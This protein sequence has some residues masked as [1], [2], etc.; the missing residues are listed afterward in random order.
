MSLNIF[1]KTETTQLLKNALICWVV[2]I[3]RSFFRKPF[4]LLPELGFVH[5]RR[6]CLISFITHFI[7]IFLCRAGL[8]QQAPNASSGKT[9]PKTEI[10]IPGP[11][12]QAG[13]FKKIFVGEHYRD[14]WT[15]PLEVPVLDLGAYAGGLT[16]VKEGGGLQTTTLRLQAV[17]G[18]QYTFRSLDKDPSRVLPP[19]LRD[20]FASN[21]LQDQTS[22]AHPYAAL[23]VAP[24]AEAVGV[25][26]ATPELVIMPDE[27][28]LGEFRQ[29]FAGMLGFIEERPDE[30]PEGQPGFAESE[31]VVGTDKLFE[32]LEAD[33]NNYVDPKT[34]LKARLLDIFVGDWDRSADQWRWALF[35]QSRQ[36]V[37]CPIPRDRDHAFSKFDGLLPSIF[38]LRFVAP[39][40]EG[41]NK[42]KPDLISL[43]YSGRHLDRRF[44]PRLSRE[45]FQKIASIF[46]DMLTDSV[47][48]NAV[49]HLPEPI[50]ATSGEALVKKLKFRRYLLEEG[51]Y[52]YYLQLAKYVDLKTC[53]HPDYVEVIRSDDEHVQV[54]IDHLDEKNGAKNDT[55][56]FQR[57]FNRNETHEIRLY[58]LGGNDKVVISGKVDKSILVRLIGGSGKDEI[59]DNSK[60]N[61][62]FLDFIPLFPDAANKTLIYDTA[63]DTKIIAGP[64]SVLKT[65]KFDSVVNF[66]EEQPAVRDYGYLTVPLPYLSVDADNGLF[67]GIGLSRYYYGF[68]KQ[69]YAFKHAF[70]GNYAFK[71]S[72]YQLHYLGE[73][74]LVTNRFRFSLEGDAWVPREVRNFYGFGNGT[75]RDAKR[76][77]ADFYRVR[78]VEYM[79]RPAFHYNAA[80]NFQFS[81]GGA[82][83]HF[84]TEFDADTTFTRIT[85]PYGVD[86]PT[87]LEINT[88]LKLDR[89]DHPVSAQ[90]GFYLSAKLSHFPQVFDNE[91]AFT[92]SYLDGRIYLTPI[93]DV[94]FAFQSLAQKVWGSFPYYEAA[95]LGG[96]ESLRGFRRFRFAGDAALNGRAEMRMKFFRA[97]VIVPTSF[98]ILLFGDT[99][100]VWFKNE[101]PGN[102]HTAFGAGVWFAPFRRRVTFSIS[103]ANSPEGLHLNAGGGFAF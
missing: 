101:S 47:I 67:L 1:Q 41:F 98:G 77:R 3:F 43:T 20:T 82:V 8:A 4:W 29:R 88:G 10:R 26:H 9:N 79:A 6:Y 78:S 37:W 50:Y 73:Y 34:F 74:I 17:N 58:L 89:R 85:R 81:L 95:F 57:T 25:L 92:K 96:R 32:R 22:T 38:D 48:E 70:R 12:Y 84:D 19:D 75:T 23:V 28:R 24:L 31:K 94:T 40:F 99:G 11:R 71:T 35:P 53:N 30:G 33:C 36:K 72:Q 42:N 87:L 7:F 16:P 56:L 14:L 59:I 80:A 27:E 68:R 62:A 103:A 45:E 52:R 100:R 44:L 55:R 69:P 65:G 51:A 64:S 102:W 63:A 97:K 49:R 86:V 60:V 76:E 46:V 54:K 91:S 83:K 18:A 2:S 5:V 61:G 90:K 15:T 66:Y 13:G 39:Q 93:R 21:V